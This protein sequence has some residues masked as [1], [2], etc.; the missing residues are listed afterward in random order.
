MQAAF[1][2]NVYVKRQFREPRMPAMQLM[3]NEYRSYDK[4]SL[5]VARR[6]ERMREAL[7][8]G[9]GGGYMRT[10]TVV[11]NFSRKKAGGVRSI[12]GRYMCEE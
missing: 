12:E 2:E 8:C 3:I 5:E 10:V 1:C 4:D 9:F 6:N 11:P 7:V